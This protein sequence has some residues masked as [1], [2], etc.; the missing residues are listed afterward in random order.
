[1]LADRAIKLITARVDGE[2]RIGAVEV[3]GRWL[4]DGVSIERG[5][6]GRVRLRGGEHDGREFES[7]NALLEFVRREYPD[8]GPPRRR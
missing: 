8:L 6:F 2:I 5:E 3:R 7:I 4:P 1:M